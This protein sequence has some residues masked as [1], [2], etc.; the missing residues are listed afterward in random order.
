MGVGTGAGVGVCAVIAVGEEVGSDVRATAE[1]AGDGVAE[2][3][4]GGGRRI[5][6]FR[7]TAA[8]SDQDDERETD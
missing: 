2:P 4:G 5:S 6:D 8:A 1:L 3:D 7:V